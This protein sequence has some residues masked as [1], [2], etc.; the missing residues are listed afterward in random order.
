MTSIS[1]GTVGNSGD[2]RID[3]LT[4]GDK[5]NLAADRTVTYS[6]HIATYNH[7]WSSD[8]IAT[9][10]AAF[11]AWE[12]VANIN[13]VR[14]GSW[15]PWVEGINSPILTSSSDIVVMHAGSE[16]NDVFEIDGTV[17]GASMGLGS[18]ATFQSLYDV[19]NASGMISF[20]VN[21]S[22]Y[23]NIAGDILINDSAS[24][25]YLNLDAGE[26]GFHTIL[27]EIG[28]SLGLQHWGGDGYA[29]SQL[30]TAMSY[31]SV[32][33]YSW[34]G[35]AATPMPYDILA[36][37]HL[38]G[39]NNNYNTGDDTYLIARDNQLKTI[40]DAGGTDTF[41]AKNI[42]SY[43][44]VVIDLREGGYSKIAQY[45]STD[46]NDTGTYE[47]RSQ[48]AVA[49]NTTI[50]NGYGHS[51]E[52]H[53]TGNAAD[54]I[55]WGR[56]AGND[57]FLGLAGDDHIWVG[58]GSDTAVGGDGHDSIRFENSTSAVSINLLTNSFSGGY[59]ANDNYSEI[60]GIRGS[61]YK[62]TLS[63]DH[64]VNSIW[65]KLGD[66]VI[67]GYAGGDDLNGEEGSD[68]LS[69]AGS[70]AGVNV[71]IANN[72]A[73]GGYAEGDVIENF[74]HLIGSDANDTLIGTSGSNTLT[75]GN[76]DDTLVTNGGADSLVGLAGND[77]AVVDFARWSSSLSFPSLSNY[78]T[79]TSSTN[80]I[81]TLTGV[82]GRAF[83]EISHNGEFVAGQ[84]YY[85]D[86]NGDGK[87]DVTLQDS[88][89]KFWLS[90]A[91]G[92]GLSSTALGLQHGGNPVFLRDQTQFAD[93]NG[94]GYKDALFQGN[95]NRFWA[96]KGSVSG[97]ENSTLVMTHGGIMDVAMVKYT[98]MTGDGKDDMMYHG[99]DNR[100][101]MSTG[102]ADGF[103]GVS[104]VMTHGG[105]V[106]TAAVQYADINGDD[107]EDMI[108]HGID[109][110]F[111]ASYSD[112]TQFAGATL[113]A[114]HGGAF[115]TEKV[116][117]A[118]IN[119][120]GKDDMIYQAMIIVFG[121]PR[122]MEPNLPGHH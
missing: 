62:D 38:Y 57:I 29:S 67:N 106:N 101:W 39:A 47:P 56:N 91:G 41:D 119:G 50:E 36:I 18:L 22:T 45:M 121:Y 7:Y 65:G 107:K 46:A 16:L 112:G 21:S 43:Y 71:D 90:T 115:N 44:D 23:P 10:D 8:E 104:H 30:Y 80:T 12:N 117:Y 114:Q 103:A 109:N 118:D 33:G 95:D 87:M 3:N 53:I 85:Q 48:T 74:E 58:A 93:I 78:G 17:L 64:G 40:W 37:Q 75:G 59:A 11:Q 24:D 66:D 102:S 77:T 89:L 70:N 1:K 34:A 76:G 14:E 19:Y 28:H 31:N 35:N 9:T 82:E 55:L 42:S 25:W 83:R 51:G 26:S 108:Y 27:H 98:D 105:P 54:N 52:D 15:Y 20:D 5:W 100:F 6:L 69:Y 92:G 73:S 61:D 116:Q 49:F 88:N 2:Y 79:I 122:R 13:F 113:A 32:G 72:I 111:W 97:F 96:N 60:E 4:Y 63:G 110:R 94:D 81:V 120:D 84:A 99:Q 68:T 86:V